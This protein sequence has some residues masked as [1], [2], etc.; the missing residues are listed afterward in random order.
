MKR[1]CLIFC[2]VFLLT[3]GAPVSVLA[4]GTGPAA[5]AAGDVFDFDAAQTVAD[6]SQLSCAAAALA[7]LDTGRLLLGLHEDERR[8]PASVT[9]IMTMLL[10]TE[11]VESGAVG[12]DDVVTASEH[13]CSMGGSQI[14]LEPGEQMTVRDLFKSVSIASANDAAVALA[15]FVSGSEELF[16]EAMNARAGELGM[17]DTSFRNACGLDAEGHLTSARDIARMSAALCAHPDAL[18][19]AVT[20]MDSVRD[21]AFGLTNTNKLIKTYGGL[22]G[23]KT[24]STDEAGFCISA[25]AQRGDLRLCAVILGADTSK[26]RF[27]AATALL[28]LGFSSYEK[29]DPSAGLPP[30]TAAVRSGTAGS[31]SLLPG[32][33][34][35]VL[36]RRGSAGTVELRVE[37]P[38]ILTAP[39]AAGEAVGRVTVLQDGKTLCEIP[40][41]AG[42]DVPRLGF[43]AALVRLTDRLG[44]FQSA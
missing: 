2:L 11:A 42:E 35:S 30:R 5:D 24:G 8:A 7:D 28:N 12:W 34:E 14:F 39:V 23:L 16:V 37:A 3:A 38:E 4:G 41:V 40:L 20:W 17:E 21:G 32:S 36:I 19:Y 6:L 27:E 13:A 29:L 44:L 15:E 26:D 9:K 18:T 25:T 10:V 1:L 31:V 22:T 33:R 43:W